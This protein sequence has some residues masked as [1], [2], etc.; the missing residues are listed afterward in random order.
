M[1]NNNMKN[2]NIFYRILLIAILIFYGCISSVTAQT[3]MEPQHIKPKIIK[4]K[5]YYHDTVAII[6]YDLNG[7]TICDAAEIYE[8]KDGYFI[9]RMMQ[10]KQADKSDMTME[11]R[12]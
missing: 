10:C 9:V 4:A 8:K 3:I 1:K 11:P 7:D 2:N 5:T 6:W 12:I